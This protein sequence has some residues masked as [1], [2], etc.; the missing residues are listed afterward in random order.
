[1]RKQYVQGARGPVAGAPQIQWKI[2]QIDPPDWVQPMT[3]VYPDGLDTSGR[4]TVN[5]GVSALVPSLEE[6]WI[7]PALGAASDDVDSLFRA[8]RQ[9]RDATDMFRKENIQTR[10]L[11]QVGVI[12]Y[13]A[14]GRSFEVERCEVDGCVKFGSWHEGPKLSAQ[15]VATEMSHEE[16]SVAL[17]LADGEWRPKV[18]LHRPY[19]PLTATSAAGLASDVQ[20]I[21]AELRKL[22]S[23]VVAI[24]S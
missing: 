15:H 21:L 14:W 18:T 6:I 19:E 1:M 20:W 12:H 3:T 23:S 11:P 2:R 8:V 5:L 17:I 7:Y 22:T 9:E 24:A 4:A 13:S 16:Y 10:E